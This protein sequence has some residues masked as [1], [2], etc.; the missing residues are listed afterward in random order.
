L[1]SLTLFS[2]FQRPPFLKLRISSSHPPH[3]L[4]VTPLFQLFFKKIS[5][6][7]A[8]LRRNERDTRAMASPHPDTRYITALLDNDSPGIV[9]IYSRFAARIRRFV[10]A[11][12]GHA[13]DARDVMQEALLAITRQARRERFVLTCPF[14]AYLYCVSRGKWLNELQRRQRE[15]TISEVEGYNSTEHADVLAEATLL[16]ADRDQLFRRCY[17]NLSASCRQILQLSWSGM[18][19]E[20]V[21]TQ[22]GISYGYVRKRKSECLAQ[23]IHQIKSSPKYANLSS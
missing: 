3:R 16:E 14:E 2:A 12:N 6:R 13:E 10:E 17:E 11:N 7:P 15:V 18:P 21:G 8:Y 9:E 19:M 22:M 4:F 20:S 23:L 1:V 5:V